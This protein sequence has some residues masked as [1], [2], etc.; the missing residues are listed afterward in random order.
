MKR[1]LIMAIV[2]EDME[3]GIIEAYRE[4]NYIAEPLLTPKA[5]GSWRLVIDHR[6]INSKTVK[7]G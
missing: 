5:N 4:S 6:K 2:E 7:D 1:K 3:T